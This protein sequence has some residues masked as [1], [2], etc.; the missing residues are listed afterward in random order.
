LK[1]SNKCR[2][3]SISGGIGSSEANIILFESMTVCQYFDSFP[4]KLTNRVEQ[5]PASS[6]FET[7]LRDNSVLPDPSMP[8]NA[9]NSPQP[10]EPLLGALIPFNGNIS[11]IFY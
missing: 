2:D 11:V 3:W 9:T 7:T 10:L 8:Q 6:I 1:N 4:E 5:M